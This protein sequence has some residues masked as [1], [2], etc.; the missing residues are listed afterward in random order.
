[1]KQ[2][3][4]VSCV[5]PTYN[6]QGFVP[7]AVSYFLRQT[8]SNRELLVIDDSD[9]SVEDLI[10]NHENIRYIR[11]S[12]KHSLGTKRNIGCEEAHGDIV[13]FWDDDDWYSPYRLSFQVSP[14]LRDEADLSALDNPMILDLKTKTFC[15]CSA[16]IQQEMFAHA[17]LGG[18]ML[19]WKK[20]WREGIRFPNYS[21]AEETDFLNRAVKSGA[22]LNKVNSHGIYIYLRHKDNTW[23]FQLGKS[24]PTNSTNDWKE[25]ETPCFVPD[26]DLHFYG[27][28]KMKKV[29]GFNHAV[30]E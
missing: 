23:Q 10:P 15:V 24:R 9:P 1:M 11:I 19:F 21:L 16:Q 20:I 27:V 26:T 13:T 8:Y 6:R 12:R 3:P 22:N 30:M 4:L 29:G 2:E 5:M 18:T 14:L 17:V 28:K 25:I 7:Q